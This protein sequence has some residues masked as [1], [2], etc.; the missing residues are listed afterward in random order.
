VFVAGYN[1]NPSTMLAGKI[2][3][4]N[5]NRKGR[6]SAVDLL[7]PTSLDQLLFLLYILFIFFTKEASLAKKPI[8]LSLSLQLVFP[9]WSLPKWS[10]LRLFHKY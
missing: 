1:L 4:G 9:D 10:Y 5:P 6:L 2:E 7:V 3:A 8:V